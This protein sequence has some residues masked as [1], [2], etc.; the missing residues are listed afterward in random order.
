M[1]D[2]AINVSRTI[3]LDPVGK[4]SWIGRDPML[5]LSRKLAFG[6]DNRSKQHRYSI[7]SSARTMGIDVR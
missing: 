3:Q 4:G 2:I 1:E 5:H 6:S 7:T